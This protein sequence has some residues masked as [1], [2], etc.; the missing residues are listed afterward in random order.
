MSTKH[1]TSPGLVGSFASAIVCGVGEV[2]GRALG[3]A[4]VDAVTKR[5]PGTRS[6]E[7]VG[8]QATTPNL[9]APMLN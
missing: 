7:P 1:T 3:G 6:D 2:I 5:R 8:T 9:K 4:I